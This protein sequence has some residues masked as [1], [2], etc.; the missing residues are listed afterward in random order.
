MGGLTPREV[1]EDSQGTGG[2]LWSLARANPRVVFEKRK[3][4]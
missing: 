2:V 4:R 3:K 1:R